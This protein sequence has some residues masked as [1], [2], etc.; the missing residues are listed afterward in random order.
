M[1]AMIS[2]QPG[3]EVDRLTAVASKI[4]AS[5]GVPEADA[6]LVADSLV[7]ADL[8]G[9]H[10][11]GVSRLG[12]YVERLR[13]GGNR[14]EG[15]P[16]LV[17]EAPSLALLDAN[18]LL[19]QVASARAVELAAQ[20][21]K[22]S[23]CAAVCVRGASHFGAAGYWA[24]L[25]TE[26]GM[27]GMAST[28]TTPV[29]AAWGGSTTAIGSNP[30]AIAFPSSGDA[31]VVVD[32]AT[33][34]TTWGA[35][36]RAEATGTPIPDTWALGPDGTPTTSAVEAVAAGRLL[37]FARHKGYA[38]AVGIE[39]LSGA[40]AG[41]NC[42]SQIAHM[43][44]EPEKPMGAGLFFLA[45][46]P[47]VLP[48]RNGHSFA[49]KVHEV[50][51]SLN[52]LPPRDPGGRVLWPGQLEAERAARGDREGVPLPPA[53]IDEV[54]KLARQL[55]VA[56]SLVVGLDARPHDAKAVAQRPRVT[57]SSSEKDAET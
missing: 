29:M 41:A 28:N 31:P 16:D 15:E 3:I 50:Q 26:Q 2:E 40:L 47:T 10:S 9:I 18:G 33:S 11:H 27:L 25:I 39:L 43:Y 44:L 53:I 34:E 20:K 5:T 55:G 48:G 52:A 42:L 13:M 57:K 19:A 6:R 36:L 22:L 35:L 24:R 4:L 30:L 12:I 56:E 7:D 38:L 51:R 8:R 1:S 14:P 32:M 49:E 37:P 21:A 17:S 45:A 54:R 23:G 46:D